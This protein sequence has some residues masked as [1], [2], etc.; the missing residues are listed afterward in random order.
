MECKTN[1]RKI[2]TIHANSD[3]TLHFYPLNVI[4]DKNSTCTYTAGYTY[5]HIH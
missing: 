4:V 2:E 3:M 5:A 1:V